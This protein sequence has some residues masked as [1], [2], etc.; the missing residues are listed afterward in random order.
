MARSKNKRK[1]QQP[2]NKTEV[3]KDTVAMEDVVTTEEV[4]E[5]TETTPTETQVTGEE[6]VLEQFEHITIYDKTFKQFKTINLKSENSKTIKIPEHFVIVLPYEK[7]VKKIVIENPV[8]AL[9]VRAEYLEHNKVIVIEP[10][11]QTRLVEI[12]K[13]LKLKLTF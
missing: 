6:I 10:R 12:P 11:S 7:P 3:I 9:Q 8:I 13:N 5:K 2:T 1:Q 4:E